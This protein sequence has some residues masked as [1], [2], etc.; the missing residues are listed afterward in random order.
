MLL[1]MIFQTSWMLT[2]RIY[3]AKT[4]IERAIERIALNLKVKPWMKL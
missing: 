4:R 2:K 3:Q 1:D